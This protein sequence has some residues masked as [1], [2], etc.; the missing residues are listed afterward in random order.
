MSGNLRIL[1]GGVLV[2]AILDAI[3]KAVTVH[4]IFGSQ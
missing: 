4:L 2:F 3:E 1:G